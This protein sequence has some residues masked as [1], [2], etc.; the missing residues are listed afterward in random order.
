MII[1]MK[2]NQFIKIQA[3]SDLHETYF[4]QTDRDNVNKTAIFHMRT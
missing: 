4:E 3:I 1:P 2:I